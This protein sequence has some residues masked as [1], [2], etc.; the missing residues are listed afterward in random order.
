[1]P[2]SPAARGEVLVVLGPD[3]RPPQP[4]AIASN[5]LTTVPPSTAIPG[6]YGL[7]RRY[8]VLA[9]WTSCRSSHVRVLDRVEV[10]RAAVRVL[11]PAR[12]AVDGP[13]VEGGRVVGLDRPEVARAVGVDGDHPP[14]RKTGPV[15]APED[16][17]HVRGDVAMDDDPPA[18]HVAVEAPVPRADETEIGRAGPDTPAATRRRSSWPKCCWIPGWPWCAGSLATSKPSTRP[19]RFHRPVCCRCAGPSG[20]APVFRGRH[21]ALM[22]AARALR[23]RT[24]GATVET[25]IGL[26]WTTGMRVGEVL[27]LNVDD[28]DRRHRGAHRVAVQVRQVPPRAVGAKHDRRA[29]RLPCPAPGDTDHPAMFVT[30]AGHGSA[31]QGSPRGSQ[32][33]GPTGI[34]TATAAAT[35]P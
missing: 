5:A 13:T 16:R 29:R 6:R 23:R 25:I 35:R 19:T 11:R 31:T 28:L 24:W 1:M 21:R 34:T 10:D 33:V 12:R 8:G 17:E 7:R 22:D 14:D 32:A 26:L 9:R 18:V 20:P 27:R 2:R 30:P 15:Q 4:Q 3:Q